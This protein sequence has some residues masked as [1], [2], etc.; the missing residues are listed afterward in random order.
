MA[1]PR[2]FVS[3]SMSISLEVLPSADK[4]GNYGYTGIAA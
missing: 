2:I 1:L 3:H 4:W